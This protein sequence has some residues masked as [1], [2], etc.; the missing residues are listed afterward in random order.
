MKNLGL[1]QYNTIDEFVEAK[2]QRLDAAE[3]GF[4]TLFELMFSEKE[5][6]MYEQ[7]VGYR[8]KQTTYGEAYEDILRLSG[9]V[10]RTLGLP[11][12]AIV[13][14]SMDN[15]LLWLEMFWAILRAGYRPLLINLRL[16][17]AAV[18][19]AIAGKQSVK[20]IYVKGRLVNLV[21]R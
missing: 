2:L 1:G 4:D 9:V 15:S 11:A 8:M 3:A 12:N 18:A 7:S 21:V 20:E 6:L 10:R 5:N 14:L 17:D 16:S 13:G 19:Q